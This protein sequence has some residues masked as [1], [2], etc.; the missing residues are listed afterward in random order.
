MSGR[1]L[2]VLVAVCLLSGCAHSSPDAQPIVAVPGV[3]D[4]PV[5]PITAAPTVAGGSQPGRLAAAASG[6]QSGA[7]T[8][9]AGSSSRSAITPDLPASGGAAASPAVTT[10]GQSAAAVSTA[11]GG[12]ELERKGTPD[13]S[14][15]QESPGSSQL[16]SAA[17][18]CATP[19]LL[20]ATS[21]NN[22]PVVS[23][24]IDGEPDSSIFWVA[25]KVGGVVVGQGSVLADSVG[26]FTI[27]PDLDPGNYTF[28]VYRVAQGEAR[29]GGS[30]ACPA[31]SIDVT[32]Q[33]PLQWLSGA[34]CNGVA[35][36]QFGAWRQT[37][38]PIAGTW[39]SDNN[40]MLGLW[41]LRPGA[42]YANW[43]G[44]L[45]IAVGA[46]GPGETWAAAAR[47]DYDARW[48]A[49][50]TSMS[51]LWASHTGTLYI[52]FAHEFNG[53]WYSWKVT[54]ATVSDFRAA[55]KR[56][57]D[58][59]QQYFPASRLVFSP[60]SETAAANDLDWRTA[61]PGASYVDVMSVD[62]Y[63]MWP[64]VN[65][66]SEFR[67][68]ALAFDS[69]GAPRGIQRH[70]EHAKAVGLPFAVSEWGNNSSFGDSAVFMEQMHEFFVENAGVGAGKLKY[71]V[72]F[73]CIMA[74]D[75]YQLYPSTSAPNAADAYKRLF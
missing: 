64:W 70:L 62:Y 54:G 17:V 56:Y 53:D 44:D 36:G 39:V 25:S 45:D 6:G 74:D 35:S 51:Q 33:V 38:V 63:N 34:A 46:I 52:R 43:S 50:L 66:E 30:V 29:T 58:L 48:R 49:S 4:A 11:G 37:T 9:S 18:W 14:R 75:P 71:E 21:Q 41:P 32:I 27:V 47:G 20:L 57:R 13:G 10:E 72:L 69:F 28:S 12:V 31:A 24:H 7:L 19:S 65:S 5:V 15:A 40:S 23:G 2:P 55:W 60:N 16:P 73:N 68:N 61:F 42:E 8:A 22:T 59:Q 3:S 26:A 67:R 1:L